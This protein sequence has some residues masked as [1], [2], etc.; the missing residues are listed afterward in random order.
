MPAGGLNMEIHDNIFARVFSSHISVSNNEGEYNLR[1]YRNIFHHTDQQ[2]IGLV[3]FHSGK[4]WIYR[5]VIYR[6][7][8]FSK[9]RGPT[10]EGIV[11]KAF[12][13]NNT[14]VCIKRMIGHWYIQPIRKNHVYLNNVFYFR[15]FRDLK[16]FPRTGGHAERYFKVLHNEGWKFYPFTDGPELDYNIYWTPR[17][18]DHVMSLIKRMP[19]ETGRRRYTR[20]TKG[21]YEHWKRKLGIEPHGIQA[22]PLLANRAEFE[23]ADLAKLGYDRLS[24]MDYRKIIQEGYEKLFRKQFDELYNLF[25]LSEDSLAIDRG[26]PIPKDWPDLSVVKDGKPDIGAIE[27]AAGGNRVN[28]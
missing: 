12:L 3:G 18:D 5:N 17:K 9:N 16:T 2:A 11:P 21:D 20:Y 28:P 27:Y 6:S 24:T 26:T 25:A 7:G 10:G 13:Y 4:A 8:S 1:V 14:L 15:T 19:P 23:K 22:D